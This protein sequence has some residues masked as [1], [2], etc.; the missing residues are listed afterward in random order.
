L[1]TLKVGL[2]LR[3]VEDPV[4]LLHEAGELGSERRILVGSAEEVEQLLTDQV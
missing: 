2:D 3:A 4:D 1:D